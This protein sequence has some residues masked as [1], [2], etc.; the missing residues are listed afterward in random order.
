VSVQGEVVWQRLNPTLKV[1]AEDGSEN[2][3]KNFLAFSLLTA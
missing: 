3:L 1:V 2:I